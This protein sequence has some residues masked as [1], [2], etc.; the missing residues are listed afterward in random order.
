VVAEENDLKQL[1]PVL[2]QVREEHGRVADQSVLDGG[3]DS[4]AQ[5]ARAE[6]QQMPVL[7]RLREDSDAKGD[8][9]KAHFRYDA[10]EN[11]Y[12]CPRGEKLIQIG[13]NR[14]KPTSEPDQIYRCGNK[15]C[16]VRMQCSKDSRGRKIRRPP[17]EEARDRQAEKQQ[18]PRLAILL[19]LRKEIV[20]HIFGI[21]KTIDGFQ[22]FTVRG[23]AKV[24][25]QWAL[26]CLGVNLRKLH[27]LA[28]WQNGQLVP[29][30]P[31]LAAAAAPAN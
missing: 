8:F 1:T 14:S 27:A 22:R 13:T 18:D 6:E 12:V 23:L 25:A 7:V 30:A 3:Y 15:T 4:G 31:R 29:R 2:E 10:A 24:N 20:E 16:P 26:V 17:H 19:G 21:V 11:V 5:L 9:S 28:T